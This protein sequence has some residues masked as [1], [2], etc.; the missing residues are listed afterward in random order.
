MTHRNVTVGQKV[1]YIPTNLLS[2]PRE[3]M[4]LEKNIGIVTSMNDKFIFVRY[5]DNEGSQAT[6]AGDLYT[7][8]HRP[9]LAA[10]I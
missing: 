10:L 1:L 2:K 7:L 9:D 8:E 6:K 4:I 3:A 5:K